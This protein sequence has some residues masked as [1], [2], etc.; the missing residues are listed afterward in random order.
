MGGQKREVRRI[1]QQRKQGWQL[2][3]DVLKL[4]HSFIQTPP[5]FRPFRK[6]VLR[7]R[8]QQFCFRRQDL[9]LKLSLARGC[10]RLE[11]AEVERI[12][13]RVVSVTFT[14][15]SRSG[16]VPTSSTSTDWPIHEMSWVRNTRT[17]IVMIRDIL[18]LGMKTWCKCE[19]S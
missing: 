18:G 16:R 2:R 13:L 7:T 9:G 6:L 1:I 11:D 10:G 4:C 15:T 12:C 14:R 3:T 8:F 19:A 5:Q 17:K